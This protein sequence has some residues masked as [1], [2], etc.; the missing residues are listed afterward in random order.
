MDGLLGLAGDVSCRD[1]VVRGDL[2]AIGFADLLEA[3]A[4]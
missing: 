1:R 3:R 2:D 4:R